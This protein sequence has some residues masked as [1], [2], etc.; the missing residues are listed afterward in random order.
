MT[1]AAASA[2]GEVLARF[3]ESDRVTAPSFYRV[4]AAA[5]EHEVYRA[6]GSRVGPATRGVAAVGRALTN[7]VAGRR[8]LEAAAY[9]DAE[10]A[11]GRCRHGREPAAGVG[12]RVRP[13]GGVDE[14][15]GDGV[16]FA[17]E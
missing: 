12:D 9:A 7:G 10:A 1:A 6:V 17:E 8:L 2:V 13:G 11:Y 3:H 16:G 14:G 4:E 15:V 5:R